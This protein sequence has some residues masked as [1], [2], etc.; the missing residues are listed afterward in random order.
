MNP[1]SSQIAGHLNKAPIK[2]QVLSLLIGF[3]SDRQPKRWRLFWFQEERGVR[4]GVCEFAGRRGRIF[5]P[6]MAGSGRGG[7]G[8][9]CI[10]YSLCAQEQPSPASGARHGSWP[11]GSAPRLWFCSAPC[12]GQCLAVY[13]ELA[14]TVHHGGEFQPGHL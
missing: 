14:Q 9:P 7:V 6:R 1:P 5:W 12:L 4:T 10:P 11:A 8:P 2:I 13:L 3:G